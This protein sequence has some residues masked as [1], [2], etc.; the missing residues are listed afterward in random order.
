MFMLRR[1]VHGN[2]NAV[3]KEIPFSVLRKFAPCEMPTQAG[4]ILTV[5]LE[6]V[7]PP[8]SPTTPQHQMNNKRELDKLSMGIFMQV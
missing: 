8:S 7:K 4:L 3:G 1:D 6:C 2:S 5:L